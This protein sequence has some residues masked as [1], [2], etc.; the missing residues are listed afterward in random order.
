MDALS[1]IRETIPS[2]TDEAAEK[3]RRFL[4]MLT[5]W[6]A[7]MNLTAITG[8]RDIIEKHFADSLLPLSLIPHAACCIDVG[9]GAGFPGIPLKIMRPDIDMLLLDSL[10]KRIVFLNAVIGALGLTGITCVHA[11]AEEAARNPSLRGHFDV[12]LSRAVAGAGTLIELT[13]PFLKK[14]GVSLMYKGPKA[15]EELK[16]SARALLL[17]HA[18]AH[19]VSYPAAWGERN[20]I[21]VQKRGDTPAAYP[22]KSAIKNPL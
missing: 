7:K 9:T 15:Q 14:G 11:R 17:L 22:R 10:H 19:T 4:E 12:A 1:Q 18:D 3:F 8:P 2:V 16:K 5:D 6:N 20:I 21:V 13:V